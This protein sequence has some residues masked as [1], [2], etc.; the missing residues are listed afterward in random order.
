VPLRR[1]LL[2]MKVFEIY[3]KKINDGNEMSIK[4]T[5]GKEIVITYMTKAT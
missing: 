3:L 4:S 1:H 5:I 2:L